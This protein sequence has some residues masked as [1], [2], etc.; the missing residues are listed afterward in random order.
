MAK[1][2][3]EAGKVAPLPLPV[4]PAGRYFLAHPWKCGA[5]RRR[6]SV[7]GAGLDSRHALVATVL[8]DRYGARSIH[9]ERRHLG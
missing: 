9:P 6:R 4:T 2:A 8:E 3:I 5:S 7:G 1:V